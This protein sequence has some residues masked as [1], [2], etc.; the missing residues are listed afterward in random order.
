MSLIPLDDRDGVIWFDGEFVNWRDAKTHVLCH[1]LHYASSAFEGERAYNG[2][3]F[4]ADEHHQRLIDSARMIDIELDYSVQQINQI[5]NDVLKRNNLS[6][7]Y[8]RPVVWRGADSLSVSALSGRVHFAVAAWEWPAYYPAELKARGMR[9]CFAPYDRPSPKT[10]PT[11]AKVSGLYMICTVSKND[12]ERRGYQDAMMLDYRGF[13]A[14]ATSANFFLVINGEL[15]TPTTHCILNGIT[16][17]TVI[18]LAKELG[19]PVHERDIRPEEMANAQEA[20]LTGTA[21]EIMPVGEV[22]NYRF[23]PGEITAR[24][25]AAFNKLTGTAS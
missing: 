20:F 10:A 19:I 12:A 11:A 22:E 4:K 9:I 14:E 25:T 16:R 1:A 2:K 8:V 13:I 17:Q 24:L 3:V 5:V 18:A 6:N 23:A 15:H 21:A 7:A